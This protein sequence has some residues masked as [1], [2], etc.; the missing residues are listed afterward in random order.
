MH[1][2][3]IND[4]LEELNKRIPYSPTDTANGNVYVISI[5]LYALTLMK[6]QRLRE[7]YPN[8][9]KASDTCANNTS[10]QLI[11]NHGSTILT[12]FDISHNAENKCL[13]SM[14]WLPKLHRNTAKIKF[15]IP[16]P[17]CSL[18]ALSKSITYVFCFKSF[19]K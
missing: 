5:R 2:Y 4:S 7:N 1:G 6:K 19:N 8:I 12:H 3:S 18:K 16:V 10:N 17:K 15:I 13:P 9:P 11:R 14:Y